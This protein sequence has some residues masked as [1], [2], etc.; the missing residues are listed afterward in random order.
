M[1]VS[2][3]IS[4]GNC[5]ANYLF[6]GPMIDTQIVTL[7]T[8]SPISTPHMKIKFIVWVILIN[9]WKSNDIFTVTNT[10]TGIFVETNVYSYNT[11]EQLCGADSDP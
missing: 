3:T 2:P 6:L 9:K 11:S 7:T 8:T 4:S 5:T 10:N 1:S